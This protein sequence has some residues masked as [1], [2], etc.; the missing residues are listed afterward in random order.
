VFGETALCPGEAVALMLGQAG[1]GQ[2]AAGI[3]KMTAL[4]DPRG[5]VGPDLRVKGIQG[6]RVA[7]GSVIAA[8]L[9]GGTHF[10]CVMIGT[11]AARL[12]M[13]DRDGYWWP[14]R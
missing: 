9:P 13:P 8:R 1:D 5:V 3:C 11:M 4:E 7:G 6:L 2:H 12:I 10:T 14:D